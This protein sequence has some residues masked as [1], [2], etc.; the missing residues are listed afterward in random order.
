MTRKYCHVLFVFV[1]ALAAAGFAFAQEPAPVDR[2]VFAK[3][4]LARLRRIRERMETERIRKSQVDQGTYDALH[5][6]LA[7]DIDPGAETIQGTLSLEAIAL[8]TNPTSIVLDL[9]DVLTVSAVRES[10]TPAVFSHANELLTV[11]LDGVYAPGD[12]IRL[13]IDYGGKPTADNEELGD[14]AFTFGKHGP[15]AQTRDQVVIY[16]ISE[17]F[18]ARAWWPCKDVPDD[19]ATARIRVTVP[20]TLIVASNGVLEEEI[21]LPGGRKTYVWYEKYPIAT[22]LVSLAVSNYK[23]FGD[24]FHY[25]AADSMPVV[26]YAYPEH[27]AGAQLD[28]TNTVEMLD[29][30]SGLFGLYPFVEEKY[31]M[32]EFG[33]LGAMEHQTCTSM[34][35]G[36]FA[37]TTRRDD[38]VVAHELSHQWWGDLVTPADWADVWL[39]EGFATYCEALWVEHVAGPDSVR[40][41]MKGWRPS[42]GFNG[43]LYDPDDLFGA[44][45]YR[46]GGWTLHM[47]RRVMGE[48][49]FFGA[50]RDYASETGFGYKNA[51]TADFQRVCEGR[52]GKS[53]SWFFDEWV[54][55]EGEPLYAYYWGGENGGKSV[56][57]TLRQLQTGGVFTMP[58]DV[59][60]TFDPGGAREDTTVTI[61]N[62]QLL[63]QYRFDFDRAVTGVVMDPDVW[64][65]ATF[66]ER[67]LEDITLS[68]VP[69]PFNRGTRVAFELGQGGS[70]EIDVY[71]V[72]GARVRSVFRGT[73]PAGYHEVEWDGRNAAGEPVSSGVYFVRLRAG[74]LTLV[75]K[76]VVVE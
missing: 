24:Y 73:R 19:K 28:F 53:L 49:G 34:G 3:D 22:Y 69:N 25:G 48:D 58:I 23:V 68:I 2:A 30:F 15:T 12:T 14:T 72:T 60:F 29:L 67:A 42:W 59:R 31:G 37:G 8:T 43:T 32:A 62:D 33:W 20:D 64:V 16:T 45:V 44:T 21:G 46:K 65:L 9:F 6:D 4:E 1:C 17:P 76:A 52:Y 63:A 57:L 71:D 70:V 75:R 61:W 41:Y 39:N 54:Y 55:G 7:L 11:T 5:Y 50:L 56:N 36:F 47:L 66:E 35:S 38:W 40:D 26:C 10:G 51:T 27:L 18:F 13:E 74:A